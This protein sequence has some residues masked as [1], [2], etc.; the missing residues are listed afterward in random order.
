MNLKIKK[1]AVLGAGVMGAQIA[2]HFANIGIEVLLLDMAPKELKES[3]IK[4]GLHHPLVRNRLT[5]QLFERTL[6]LKPDPLYKKEFAK[7]ISLGNFDEDL[8]QITDCDWV[9][10]AI[11]ENLEIKKNLY[12]KVEIY[13]KPDT[14]ITTNTSGIPIQVLT[15]GRSQNFKQYFCGTHFFNPPRYLKLLEIIPAKETLTDVAAF[16]K[17]YGERFLG[18]SVVTCKD[19]PAFIANRVGIYSMMSVV[20]LMK[21]MDFSVQE[22]DKLTGI[23]IGRPKSATFRTCDVVGLDT[24]VFVARNLQAVLINDESKD[25][26]LVPESIQKMLDLKWLGSKT[27]QGFYKKVKSQ[28]GQS[29]ILS[30][31]LKSFEYQAKQRLKIAEF[32][33]AKALPE[34]TKRIKS[35]ISGNSKINLFYQKLF[36]GLFT[37]ISN[38]IPEISDDLY[39][40]DEAMCAGFAW[41]IGPFEIWDSLGLEKTVPQMEKLGMK[42]AAWI[43]EMMEKKESFYQLQDGHKQYYDTSKNKHITIPGTEQFISLKNIR[44][45][46]T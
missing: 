22:I 30:L 39:K 40:I 29:E 4:L 7:R 8:P 2:C 26:F 36:Y 46:Q 33:K 21:E 16:L 34:L 19:T 37:Y 31:D 3:E 12:E 14:L 43:Y 18:K 38:R 9:I 35:L 15:H 17:D 24:L 20:H 45:S 44:S 42:P 5:R 25:T 1:V 11:V 10:E 23:I 6:K 41:E 32:E 27:K 13:R 28:D